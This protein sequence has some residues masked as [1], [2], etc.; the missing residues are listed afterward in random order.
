MGTRDYHMVV[1]GELSPAVAQAFERM[2]MT[3]VDGRTVIAGPVRDQAEL[4]ALLRRIGDLGLT[5]VNL[6]VV[7]DR[8]TGH[9]KGNGARRPE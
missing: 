2:Q 6:A 7:P 4:H 3:P 8:T 5:L 9:T 1:E